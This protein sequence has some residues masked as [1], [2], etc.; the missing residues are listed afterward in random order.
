MKRIAVTLAV[1]VCA[2][3]LA[4]PALAQKKISQLEEKTAL[5]EEDLEVLKEFLQDQSKAINDLRSGA[6]KV[7][8]LEQRVAKTEKAVKTLPEA[9]KKLAK[10][11]MDVSSRVT[12]VDKRLAIVEDE[13]ARKR[14]NFSGQFRVRPQ[15][16]TNVDNFNSSLDEDQDLFA[17]QR[18]RIGMDVTPVDWM[19]GVFVLQDVRGWGNNAPDSA[20][21]SD[22]LRVHEAYLK[23]ELYPKM[24]ELKIGRQEW[25][26]GSSRMIGKSDWS[27]AGRSFDGF[28]LTVTYENFIRADVLFSILDERSATDG[29]DLLFGGAYLT[30]PYIKGLDFDLYLLYLHDNRDGARRK[31]GTLGARVGGHMPFHTPLFVDLEASVQFGTVTEGF[32]GDTAV[33]DQDHLATAYHLEVGYEIPEK[34]TNPVVSIFFDAASGDG[35]TSANLTSTNDLHS[36]F[37]PLFGTRHKILGDMD[38]WHLS[39]IWDIGGKASITPLKG[40]SFELALH[41]MHLVEDTGPLPRGNAVGSSL[42]KAI[43]TDLGFEIDLRADYRLNENIAFALGY[44][45]F[46]PGGAIEDQTPNRRLEQIADP[47]N[48]GQ[49]KDQLFDYPYGDPAHWLFMQADFTF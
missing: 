5:I 42:S 36:A 37:V 40:L 43:R 1:M 8:A 12:E 4:S 25:D 33:I 10:L 31:V 23:V 17:N 44:S 18:L 32:S 7:T 29:E 26:F 2:V 28:D 48:P 24:L 45:A 47:N 27:Q 11:I 21:R 30:V 14:V 16:V 6:A 22:P 13:L 34:V 39:N 49:T 46:I 20:D 3:L 19:T 35:N 9:D 15:I 38:L 41:S